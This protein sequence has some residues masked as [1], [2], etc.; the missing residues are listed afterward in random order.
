V[1][2]LVVDAVR[3]LRRQ[4]RTSPAPYRL[5][6]VFVWDR[7][8]DLPNVDG[9]TKVPAPAAQ[10]R[11]RLQELQQSEQWDTLITVAE[12]SF[13]N[14]P[15]WL[16]LQRLTVTAMDQ[17]PAFASARAG[18]THELC[19]LLKRRPALCD[20]Q[21]SDETPLAAPATA[22]WLKRLTAATVQRAPLSSAAANAA[23]DAPQVYD[24][25]LSADFRAAIRELQNQAAGDQSQRERFTRRFTMAVLAREA[26]EYDVALLLLQE[27]AEWIERYRLDEWEPATALNV[28]LEMDRCYRG[29]QRSGKRDERSLAAQLELV[30]GRIC[31]LDPAWA[32]TGSEVR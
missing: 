8:E 9:K 12:D 23:T 15:L 1:K 24:A 20:L 25:P 27:L 29:L 4:E 3:L 5:A 10:L 32:V 16:D 13:F 6:R 19:Q 18:I 30:L 22:E 17:L 7:L 26:G 14:A 31:R 21:F 28:W 2:R 11:N